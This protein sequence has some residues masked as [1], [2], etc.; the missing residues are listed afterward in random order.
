[1]KILVTGATGF[2]GRALVAEL[3]R[4]NFSVSITVRSKFITI[5]SD[6]IKQFI[7]GDFDK[8]SDFSLALKGVDCVLHLAGK[9]HVIDKSK[10]FILDEFR[11]INTELTLNIARQAVES[12]VKRLVFL[13]SIGVNGDQTNIP[14]LESDTPNPQGLYAISKY[15]AEQG[16]L[17]IAQNSNLEVVIIRP[18][19]V[20]GPN[21]PGN[22]SRLINWT[23]TK[24]PLP[25]PLGA[26]N[27][28]RSLVAID[29]LVDFIITCTIHKYAANE[30]F[31]ISDNQDLSTTQLIR[32]IAKSFN[33]RLF[34]LP[35]PAKLMIFLL[36][37]LGKKQDAIRL[38]SSLQIDISKAQKKLNWQPKVTID[39][40]LKKIV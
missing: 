13:S 5:F 4:Q 6:E 1:M 40:Q 8:N 35:I 7:V 28:R 14:F 27:N 24:L 38:F 30:I 23:K 2:I 11:K 21:A 20:Y 17:K 18:P 29:N 19:L 3:L 31:L 32:K 25:L 22:F 16:L 10:M 34:L 9:A 12:G 39:E 36:G 15:E 37:V 26:V 33:K